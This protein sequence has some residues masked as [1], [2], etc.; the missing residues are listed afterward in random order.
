LQEDLDELTLPELRGQG[1]ERE[2]GVSLT[3]LAGVAD[4]TG[5]E[6]I[7][8]VGQAGQETAVFLVGLAEE[9]EFLAGADFV[10]G[11]GRDGRA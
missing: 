2:V 7:Q 1:L 9:A 3:D 6:L 11:P 8:P 5:P 10:G 4:E